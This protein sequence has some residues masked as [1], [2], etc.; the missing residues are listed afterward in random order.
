MGVFLLTFLGDTVSLVP[1]LLI[2]DQ[3]AFTDP[4][5]LQESSFTMQRAI[6]GPDWLLLLLLLFLFP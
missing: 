1:L 6:L 3:S 2:V 4:P 5:P